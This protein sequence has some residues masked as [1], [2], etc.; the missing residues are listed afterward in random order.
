LH[1]YFKTYLLTF[2]QLTMKFF[3]LLLALFATS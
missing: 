1:I 3:F 2:S